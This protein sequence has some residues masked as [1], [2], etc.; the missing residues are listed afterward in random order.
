MPNDYFGHGAA[1]CPFST[2]P[3]FNAIGNRV[4]QNVLDRTTNLAWSW[5][6]TEDPLPTGRI[7]NSASDSKIFREEIEGFIVTGTTSQNCP[8]VATDND[9]ADITTGQ[10]LPSH[11]L[12]D[13]SIQNRGTN[14]TT[15][16]EPVDVYSWEHVAT[17]D[18][19]IIEAIS[20]ASSSPLFVQIVNN[21]ARQG[22]FELKPCTISG[23]NPHDLRFLNFIIACSF[24]ILLINKKH[25]EVTRL[26][27]QKIL[28]AIP[29]AEDLQTVPSE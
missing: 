12:W 15:H 2:N 5:G 1:C 23:R 6:K 13:S 28:R 24:V 21:V 9:V 20:E 22:G 16:G 26:N 17:H 25:D 19:P 10:H 27:D 3:C 14:R 11:A 4:Q 18:Q 7:D 29:L 8:Y